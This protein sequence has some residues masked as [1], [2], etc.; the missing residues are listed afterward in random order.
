M[1]NF[2]FNQLSEL[3]YVKPTS[4]A[5]DEQLPIFERAMKA[6]RQKLQRSISDAEGRYVDGKAYG[7]AKP[8]LL[9]RV[10][11][12]D[13]TVN[14]G[15]GLEAE[16]CRV[17]LKVGISKYPLGVQTWKEDTELL[18]ENG[19]VIARFSKGEVKKDEDGNDVI[20]YDEEVASGN[21]IAL[22]NTLGSLL[23][24]IDENR[25]SEE[26]E[27]FAGM[28]IAGLKPKSAPSLTQNPGKTGWGYDE[29]EDRWIAVCE[30]DGWTWNEDESAFLRTA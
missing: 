30:A 4:K 28:A 25:D 18:D 15:D 16:V 22:L 14:N 9:W 5:K 13:K 1:K 27:V 10:V 23:D 24:F 12:T 3:A 21:L 11:K 19:A 8:S 29:E 26:A 6:A 2:N 20:K 7:N 17:N